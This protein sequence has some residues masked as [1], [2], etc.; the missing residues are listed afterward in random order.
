MNFFFGVKNF[1][2]NSQLTIPRFQNSKPTKKKYL[3]YQIKIINGEWKVNHM[4]HAELNKDFYQVNSNF[5][6]NEDIFCLATKDE[7]IKLE[8][9]NNSRL[10]NLNDYTDT[11]PNFRS[12]LQVSI[13]GGGFSSYQSEYPFRMVKTKGSILSPLSSLCNINADQN[14]IFLEIF[15]NYRFMINLEFFLL[16]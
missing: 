3:I 13:K 12:N 10:L 8:K 4:I 5:I 9:Y 1:I 11:S 2:L 7:I 14:I 16:I 6:D 15:M